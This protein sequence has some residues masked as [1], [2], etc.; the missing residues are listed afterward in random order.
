MADRIRLQIKSALRRGDV[1]HA[2]FLCG[3]IVLMPESAR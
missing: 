3:I 2:M 1:K